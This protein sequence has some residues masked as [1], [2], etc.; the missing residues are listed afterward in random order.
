MK[1]INIHSINPQISLEFLKDRVILITG[2]L[3]AER[4]YFTEFIRQYGGCTVDRFSDIVDFVLAGD[5]AFSRRTSKI[6][7]AIKADADIMSE[8]TFMTCCTAEIT[9]TEAAKETETRKPR[10]LDIPEIIPKYIAMSANNIAGKCFSI[11]ETLS[12]GRK[13][14]AMF[15]KKSGAT[16]SNV[17]SGRVQFLITGPDADNTG[18]LRKA[19]QDGI[20]ILSET[21][22]LN[23]A[24]VHNIL[25]AA[26]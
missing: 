13:Q 17:I 21:D 19:K 16:F 7:D 2:T 20:T 1:T 22:F 14:Y 24:G 18:K 4:R 11:T 12:A 15:I 9:V 25:C 6:T 3:S 10:G 26:G 8:R 23:M 5:D